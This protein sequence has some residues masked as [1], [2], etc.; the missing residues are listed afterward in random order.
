ME[1]RIGD[2]AGELEALRR[3]AAVLRAE[4]ARL[5]EASDGAARGAADRMPALARAARAIVGAPDLPAT[6]QAITD[7]AREIVG[8]HQSVCSL[9]RGPDWSQ[10][11]TAV[12]LSDRYARWAGYESA[13]DGS[14]VYAW[15]CEGNLTV[16]MTQAE[17]EAHPRWRGFGP[18]AARHPPM[19]GW[20]ATALVGRD[21]RNLG[22]VQLSDRLE[23]EFDG[24]DEAILVQLAQLAASAV[25][26]AEAEARLRAEEERLRLLADAL[27]MLMSLVDREGRYRFVNRAYEDWFGRA[28]DDVLG[29]TM[30]EVLGAEAFGL[31][32][33]HAEAALRGEARRFEAATPRAD[34]GGEETEV[35]YLP[36]RAADGAWDGFYV[37]VADI[38][39]RKAAERALREAREAAE[40]DATRTAA[41]LGQLAEGV[42][43]TDTGG[44]IAFVNEAA[45]RIHGVARL[46]VGP[47]DY[48]ATYRL[49]TEDGA[50]YPGEELPLARAALRGEAAEEARW[51]IRRPDGREVR[52][53][54]SAR[55]IRLPDGTRIGAVLTLR[56]DTAR[57]G[58]EE[59][60]RRLNRDLE[61]EVAQR[62]AERDRIW[63][64]SNE[65]MAVFGLDGTRRA[66]NPAWAR[67]L[68][69]DE[70]TLRRTPFLDLTRPEDR[71][72]LLRALA[73][74]R[75]GQR[76]ADL[77]NRLRHADGSWRTVSWTGVPGDGVFHAIG[78][79]VTGQRQAEE[80]LRQAQKMEAVGQLTGGIAH[81]FNNLLAGIVGSL[82]LLGT[83]LRQG[84]TDGL[85]R[86]VEAAMG[87]AQ[88]AA[89][90]THRL[91]AFARRQP[92][93]PR[94]VDANAL[95][96][97]M[98]DLLRRTL[99]PAIAL[100]LDRAEGL[101]RTLCDPV[102]L[103]SALLNLCINARDAMPGG[104]RLRVG[105]RNV[106]LG[107]G[108]GD[109]GPGAFVAVE[110]A[111]TG[112]GMA[113]EVVAR[114][115]EP[116]FTTK[117]LGQGSGLGLSMVYG[118]ARQ[119]E[120]L[121]RVESQ[122]GRGTTVT[123]LL[124]RI[125][126]AA[127]RGG[128]PP[129]GMEPGGVEMRGPEIPAARRGGTALVVDDEPVVRALVAE[130]LR[131]R[132]F[133]VLEAGDGPAALELLGPGRRFDLLVTDLGLPG[134]DG[135]QLADRAREGRPDL[136]VL[137]ITGY[138]EGAIRA[139]GFL[140][141]GM[142]MLTKPF[143]VEALAAKVREL[144]ER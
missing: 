57:A 65:L 107:E 97:G 96:S 134:L 105:T 24:T 49:F 110:V 53:V 67:T 69:H 130:V 115:F 30:E 35:H 111:D 99:G 80:Q 109:A 36:R 128:A 75:R 143:A 12:S 139:G 21:G 86:Y 131:E 81:D 79:D 39:E 138:A 113:P 100:E 22:L 27:P 121:V 137:F 70:E 88:R 42:V 50:P 51:R 20:L 72:R 117:P 37:L 28:R 63:Q 87:S 127:E 60:L 29:R 135:R 133:A 142:A 103:E 5:R 2:A 18:E 82:D 16:R 3:E 102:Q 68:G 78:R 14:G 90:L 77:E 89:A 46:G 9:T 17:L 13:P 31:R 124:P 15:V 93:D 34:G 120:G 54:G 123:L 73:R 91:L 125:Q 140:R 52:A 23:G 8:A 58:A 4:N 101:W 136:K 1:T 43:V 25:E 126:D 45:A 71:P 41:I 62:T 144:L 85:G 61:A 76:I 83:R 7:A 118:F 56:D 33:H 119:S 48:S 112:L 38:S 10:A 94:P 141:P 98:E 19:R 116:F 74:L 47:E 122:E 66:I 44:R 59:E 104:G 129:G 132:D 108:E 11:I 84:R 106:L 32:R 114:A 92:L 64:N 95:L 40:R 26:K 55:P 6:L